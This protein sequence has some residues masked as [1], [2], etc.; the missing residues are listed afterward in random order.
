MTAN[1]QEHDQLRDQARTRTL[2]GAAVGISGAGLLTIGI[3]KLAV[4]R[5]SNTTAWNMTI[6]PNGVVA[7]GRF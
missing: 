7:F 3:I 5:S 1:Q 6:S 4:H 2:F